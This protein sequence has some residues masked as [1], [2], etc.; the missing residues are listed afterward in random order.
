MSDEFSAYPGEEEVLLFDGL[1][2]QVIGFKYLK[3]G[4][5]N[6]IATFQLY[7]NSRNKLPDNIDKLNY[8]L[9]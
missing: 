6:E 1:E 3:D 4:S 8:D 7:N 9:V 2:F 5:N